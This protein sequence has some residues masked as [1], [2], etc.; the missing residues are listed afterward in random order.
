MSATREFHRHKRIV[1]R[2][3]LAQR[4]AAGEHPA[5]SLAS[6]AAVIEAIKDGATPEAALAAADAASAAIDAAVAGGILEAEGGD[7]AS[8]GGHGALLRGASGEMAR[9]AHDERVGPQ[10][11]ADHCRVAR[12][13]A[14]P[15]AAPARTLWSPH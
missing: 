8:G 15:P 14:T 11:R 7:D 6:E 4:S 5:A 13:A 12:C 1:R 3:A 10:Q 2:K 9:V